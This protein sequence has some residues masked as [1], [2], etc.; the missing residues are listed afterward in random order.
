MVHGDGHC[1]DYLTGHQSPRADPGSSIS[2]KSNGTIL[3]CA[4]STTGSRHV[5]LSNDI[6]HLSGF[7][8][9]DGGC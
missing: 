7:G 9:D 3:H 1:S 5:D 2:G 4:R 8:H 6:G